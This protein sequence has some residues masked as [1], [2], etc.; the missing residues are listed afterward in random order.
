MLARTAPLVLGLAL[1]SCGGSSS[2]SSP[3]PQASTCKPGGDGAYR[4]ELYPKLSDF[5]MVRQEGGRIVPQEGVVPYDVNA[6]LFSDYAEKVRTVW[7][8]PGTTVAYSADDRLELPEGAIVTKS[9]G[10]AADLRSPGA[11]VRWVETRV[12]ARGKAGWLAASYLWDDEQKEATRRLAGKIVDVGWIDAAGAA[13]STSYLVPQSTQCIKCHADVDRIVTIGLSARQLNREL[14]YADGT[15][16]QLGRWARMGWLTGAPPSD[17]APKLAMWTD[18]AA[19]T[20]PRARAYFES[21]CAHCHNPRGDARTTGLTLLASETDRYKLGIC[22]PPVA[23]GQASGSLLYDF[24]PGKPDE[25]IVMRRM[26]A[27]TPPIAM[28]ELGRSVV[29]TEGVELTRAWI[30]GLTGDCGK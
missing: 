17:A 2:G 30:L 21:N 15:E 1:A 24:V 14:A 22:K 19:G 7:L 18:G 9:F 28:P 5:C 29:H 11:N 25:S 26:L 23:A 10:F 12:M 6:A 3:T 16:N 20:E 4:D 27:T 13:V 8:P